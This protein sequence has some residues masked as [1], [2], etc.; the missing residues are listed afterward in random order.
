MMQ[1]FFLPRILVASLKSWI[2]NIFFGLKPPTRCNTAPHSIQRTGVVHSSG[3]LQIF[4]PLSGTLKGWLGPHPQR[5]RSTGRGKKNNVNVASLTQSEIRDIILGME[6]APP[7]I[8]R[9]LALKIDSERLSGTLKIVKDDERWHLTHFFID[10][11]NRCH[12]FRSLYTKLIIIDY[13][14]Q[15]K[16]SEWQHV[17]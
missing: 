9:S 5:G 3:F 16:D 4:E 8:Q 7:S 10:Y 2:T 1:Y 14:I 15:E 13:L 17:L 6:I 11:C 12:D